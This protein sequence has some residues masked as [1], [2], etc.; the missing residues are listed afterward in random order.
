MR[1]PMRSEEE[2][3]E[4]IQDIA[5]NDD[6][7]RVV[8]MNGSR[9]NP[10]ARPDFF[11]DFDIVYVVTEVESFKRD[12]DWIKPFGELMILQL[13]EEMQDPPPSNDG[14]YAYLMQFMDGNRID[15]SL[16][17]LDKL[18][19]LGRDSQSILLMDKDGIIEPYGPPSDKDYLPTPPT[20]KAF[21][22]ST[23]EFWWVCPYVAKGLWRREITYAKHTM[24]LYVRDQLMKM[25][26][27]YVG[28]KTGFNKNPGKDGK[29]L[30]YLLEPVLWQ[31]LLDTYADADYENTWEAL[32]TMGD[33]FRTL[34]TRVAA[35]FDYEYPQGDDER[36]TAHLLHVRALPQNAAEM[37]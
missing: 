13:P 4:L 17:P 7:I 22:D 1:S 9:A 31:M 27:W 8:I 14:W 12:I 18:D 21:A 5:R 32:I 33:L 25:L 11:Q 28:V 15:L 3:L 36:V 26:D 6:R 37:Y 19:L 34:A 29:N 23:N 16:L 35:H 20:A 24:E 2:M 10:N 30:E